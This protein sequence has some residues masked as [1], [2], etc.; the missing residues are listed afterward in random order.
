M[1]TFKHLDISGLILITPQVFSDNR[2]F[3]ME[4]Y[5]KSA[6]RNIGITE[7]FVQDNQSFSLKNVLR[8]LHFQ[9]EPSEQGKL[10]R[11]ISGEIQ[12]VA[13]DIRQESPTYLQW[14]SVILSAEN[15]A[16][17]YIPPGFA[18]GFLT[19]SE[20]AEIIYKCT[21]EYYASADSGI[22]WNDPQIGI[23]W[24]SECPILSDKDA[25]LPFIIT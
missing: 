19:L 17:L 20:T 11:C 10:V 21:S 12:D 25:Q 1:F 24:M 15:K 14:Y 16:M 4:S 13:V 7:D 3:F 8:G 22:I 2:G 6:F 23:K 9:S 18:H 5:K